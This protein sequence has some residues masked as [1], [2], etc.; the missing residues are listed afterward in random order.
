MTTARQAAVVAKPLLEKNSDLALIGRHLVLLPLNHVVRSIWIDRVSNA[1]S[2]QI[3]WNVNHLFKSGPFGGN[4]GRDIYCPAGGS[5][6]WDIPDLPELVENAI[7]ESVL[8]ALRTIQSIQDYI[9]LVNCFEENRY[10]KWE[11]INTALASPKMQAWSEDGY[12]RRY[13]EERAIIAAALGELDITREY[14]EKLESLRGSCLFNH[15]KDEYEF[16]LA[17][18]RPLLQ[19]N[20]RA[21]VAEWLRTLEAKKVKEYKLEKIWQPTSFPLEQMS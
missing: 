17:H 9:G 11:E 8:P 2:F 19:K 21:G 14:C 4:W 16:V 15:M 3:H 13:P 1:R 7:S 20:D 5:W 12:P 10:A 6:R 18:L